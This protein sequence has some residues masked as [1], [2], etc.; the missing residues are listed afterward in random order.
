MKQNGNGHCPGFSIC[1]FVT[2]GTDY[3]NGLSHK[4]HGPHCMLKTGM[5][6]TWIDKMCHPQLP[7]SSQALKQWMLN[8]I[9]YD[10]V[11]NFYKTIDRIINDFQFVCGGPLPHKGYLWLQNY[12]FITI[13]GFVSAKKQPVFC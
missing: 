7:D 10:I 11:W 13:I 6:G 2:L 4:V 3:L 9:K 12:A 8:Q 1:N 5:V